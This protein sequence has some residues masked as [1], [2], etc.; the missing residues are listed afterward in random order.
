MSAQRGESGRVGWAERGAAGRE[1]GGRVL[2]SGRAAV[3]GRTKGGRV[4]ESGKGQQTSL[5]NCKGGFV[6]D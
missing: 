3:R 6:L 1:E 2:V 4:G 5:K